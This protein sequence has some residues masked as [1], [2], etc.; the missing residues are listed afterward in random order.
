MN[1]SVSSDRLATI[2]PFPTR[3]LR[4]RVDLIR[5]KDR[6]PRPIR[7]AFTACRLGKSPWPLFLA[8][9]VGSGKT[10]FVLLVCD[11][12]G[13][14]YITMT[15]LCEE[16]RKAKMG[17]LREE[18]RW[19][20]TFIS[21]SRYRELIGAERVLIIDDIGQRLLSE[22]SRETLMMALTEREGPHPMI[23]TSNLTLA[24]LASPDGANYD[25]RLVSRIGAGTVVNFDGPDLRVGGSV[26]A[27]PNRR[28]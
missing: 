14:R 17:E 11:W 8:G 28:Q 15:D 27:T 12:Y 9:P 25:D 5:D 19:T 3:R 6:V 21:E 18:A 26:L 23:L 13:G 24:E 10:R 1:A 2:E 7:D 22:H 16:Y 4:Y 20:D